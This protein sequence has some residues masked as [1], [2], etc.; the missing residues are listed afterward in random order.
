VPAKRHGKRAG[1]PWDEECHT[2]SLFFMMAPS[3]RNIRPSP[4][5]ALADNACPEFSRRWRTKHARGFLRTP[6]IAVR[7]ASI[8]RQSLL[9]TT[10]KDE[11]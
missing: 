7:I 8:P 6:A 11:N 4:V 2:G 5:Y 1:T 9:E 10:I 3:A